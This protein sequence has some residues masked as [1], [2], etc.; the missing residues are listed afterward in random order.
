M[1]MHIDED[2]WTSRMRR[3]AL[4]AIALA[5]E[6]MGD[7]AAAADWKESGTSLSFA[8]PGSAC[9]GIRFSRPDARGE[10]PGTGIDAMTFDYLPYLAATVRRNPALDRGVRDAVLRQIRGRMRDTETSRLSPDVANPA[11]ACR[12]DILTWCALSYLL[13]AGEIRTLVSSLPTGGG[14]GSAS[15]DRRWEPTSDAGPISCVLV[16]DDGT[17]A[18]DGFEFRLG[19]DGSPRIRIES[20]PSKDL[21]VLC[22]D[23]PNLPETSTKGVV[24]SRLSRLI[25]DP[26]LRPASERLR[27]RSFRNHSLRSGASLEIE[28]DYVA[29]RCAPA[30][31]GAS[32]AWEEAY[33]VAAGIPKRLRTLP[34]GTVK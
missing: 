11:W 25:D 5:A 7:P 18:V 21:I 23:G 34:H 9:A 15:V 30:P 16:P 12:I 31:A 22:V 33:D 2:E 13:P 3:H 17:I 28:C 8:T 32:F 24:G 20:S 26:V 14:S 1:Y 6:Q 10:T 27:I 19:P 29:V 4:D